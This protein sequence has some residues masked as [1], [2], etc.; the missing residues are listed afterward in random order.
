MK[1]NFIIKQNISW[2]KIDYQKQEQ[3]I[4]RISSHYVFHYFENFLAEKEIEKI[5]K[6]QEQS[7]KKIIK[8]LG[9]K[10]KKKINYYLYPSEKIKLSL[11][12][13]EGYGNA[14]WG[15]IKKIKD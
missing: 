6:I 9:I 11:M 1:Q 3:W 8:I 15:K 14:I 2:M 5:I 10:N 12:G 13:D 7:Y 4:K